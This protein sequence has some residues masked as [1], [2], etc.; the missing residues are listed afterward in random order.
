VVGPAPALL[1]PDIPVPRELFILQ[2]LIVTPP[3]ISNL[4]IKQNKRIKDKE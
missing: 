2:V 4:P 1:P 3:S